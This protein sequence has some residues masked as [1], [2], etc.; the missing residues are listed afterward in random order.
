MDKS[1]SAK[2]DCAVTIGAD[3]IQIAGYQPDLSRDKYCEEFPATGR[4]ILS[5]DLVA[6][7]L[8]DL[9]IEIRIVRDP[10]ALLDETADLEPLTEAYLAPR[11][12]KSGTFTL[13]HSFK[14]SGHFIGLVTVIEPAGERK[15]ARFEFS[16]GQTFFNFVPMILGGALVAGLLF[17]YWRHGARR[18]PK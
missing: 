18:A 16:V 8:R 7:R 10:L 9:P 3:V 17:V 6:P 14:D 11:T 1:S 13:D 12:Y 2:D 4:V 15:I 5:F